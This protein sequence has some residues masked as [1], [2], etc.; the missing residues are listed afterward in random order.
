MA[1]NL[2]ALA[3]RSLSLIAPVAFLLISG[4]ERL[5]WLRVYPSHGSVAVTGSETSDITAI[6]DRVAEQFGMRRLIELELRQ[7]FAKEFSYLRLT[8]ADYQ[9]Y[10]KSPMAPIAEYQVNYRPYLFPKNVRSFYLD[11]STWDHTGWID[12]GTSRY[13]PQEG[14]ILDALQAAL[15]NRF[16]LIRVRKMVYYPMEF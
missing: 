11:V 7:A 12:I 5:T 6:T 15:T 4:C 1:L 16:G 3:S 2:K 9:R 10:L 13:A 14:Q 8:E